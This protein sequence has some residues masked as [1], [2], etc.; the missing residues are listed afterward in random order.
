MKKGDQA[1]GD[2]GT[3]EKDKTVGQSDSDTP[4]EDKNKEEGQKAKSDDKETDKSK[5]KPQDPPEPEGD[6]GEVDDDDDDD[7]DAV[8]DEKLLKISQARLSQ[9]VEK[10]L[11]KQ[12]RSLTKKHD[13]EVRKLGAKLTR[14]EGEAEEYR[15]LVATSVQAEV[16]ALP[17]EV[18]LMA[19][20]TTETAAGLKK[21]QEWLPNAKTL[22]GKLGV[23]AKAPGNPPNPKPA[24]TAGGAATEEDTLKSVKQH[25]IYRSF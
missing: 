22:A 12:E 15:K 25:S 5:S 9:I 19:P 6:D 20:A 24:T 21:V 4:A 10:R 8:E 7:E 2:S 23:A 11:A 3:P 1:T 14:L 18:K 17:D 16:D 13:G